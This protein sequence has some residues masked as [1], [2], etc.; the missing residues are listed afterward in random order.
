MW[1]LVLVALVVDLGVVV[2][3][4]VVTKTEGHARGQVGASST[5]LVPA[6]M[7]TDADGITSV[8][9]VAQLGAAAVVMWAL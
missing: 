7:G 5:I 6:R 1:L 3:D 2:V 9:Q 4:L 8:G